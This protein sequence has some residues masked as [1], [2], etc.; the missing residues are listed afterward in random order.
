M[1][2]DKLASLGFLTKESKSNLTPSQTLQHLGYEISTVPMTLQIPGSKVRNMRREASK[3]GQQ[4]KLHSPTT[5]VLYQQGDNN[6][7][8]SLFSTMEST[9]SSD[10][11]DQCAEIGDTMEGLST[12]PNNS[13][14]GASLVENTSPAMERSVMDSGQSTDR[15]IHGRFN[16]RLGSGDQQSIV[17][18]QL[19]GNSR[20]LTTHDT[21]TLRNC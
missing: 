18:W 21:S 1:V 19:V 12:S 15:H 11:E 3:V 16:I 17:Q 9:T 4:D 6:D 8:S 10:N 13:H 2:T 5:V 14:R 20:Q 7:S